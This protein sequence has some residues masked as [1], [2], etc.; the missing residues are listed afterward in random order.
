MARKVFLSVLG[1][2]FYENCNYYT[3]DFSLETRYIQHATLS[4]LTRQT[5][6][7]ADDA[8]YILLTEKAKRDN[9]EVASD[10]RVNFRMKEKGEVE[11]VGLKKVLDAMPLAMPVYPVDIKDGKDIDEMWHIFGTVYS[12]LQENDELYFD[13]THGFRYLPMFMM[14]LGNYAK[15]MKNVSVKAVTYGNFEAKTEKGAPIMNLQSLSILQD[16][17]ASAATFKKTGRVEDFTNDVKAF[18]GDIAQKKIKEAVNLFN[19]NLKQFEGLISTCR[20]NE[21]MSGKVAGTVCDSLDRIVKANVLPAPVVEV[22]KSIDTEVKPFNETWL[23]NLRNAIVWC[24][25]YQLVQQGYTLCQE[26]IITFLCDRF[27]NL[28][29][30]HDDKKSA[31]KYR[32]Y[33]SSVLGIEK[34]KAD[35]EIEWKDTLAQNRRLTRAV[36]KLDWVKDLRRDY[37]ILTKNRNQINHAGFI[38]KISFDEIKDQFDKTAGNCMAFFNR[39]LEAPQ[40]EEPSGKVFINLSNHPSDQWEEAQMEASRQYGEC[41][42][43]PF[44][45]I[46]PA[47]DEETIKGLVEDYIQ[48]I[49]QYTVDN[50]VTVHLMGEMCFTYRMVSKLKSLGIVCVCSTSTRNVHDEGNGCRTVEFRFTQFREY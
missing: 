49:L 12:V 14:V 46:D 39:D 20:G 19:K 16:W 21:I 5:E 47:A 44:P 40:V 37:E 24:Q 42:D 33:W 35:N 1:A 18:S 29:P 43:L 7:T 25:Q 32:D 34:A 36:M 10:K 26:S 3:D 4:M 28:N 23:D 11:Y 9:W 2:S 48:R 30:Y 38:G 27:A 50:T 13:I 31:R 15:F 6:W 41:I 17:T 45:Q 22:L 8:A